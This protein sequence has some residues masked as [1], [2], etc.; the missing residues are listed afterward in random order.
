MLGELFFHEFCVTD[1]FNFLRV[2]GKAKS[3][4]RGSLCQRRLTNIVGAATDRNYGFESRQRA[5]TIAADTLWS[6]PDRDAANAGI[7][8]PKG[9][10]K[11]PDGIDVQTAGSLCRD[12]HRSDGCLQSSSSVSIYSGRCRAERGN[13]VL[14]YSDRTPL[15]D[16]VTFGQENH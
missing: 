5:T 8:L 3:L 1:L 14:L 10:H 6:P 9:D 7:S 12:S 16:A 4:Y 15:R 11:R 2:V 13:G